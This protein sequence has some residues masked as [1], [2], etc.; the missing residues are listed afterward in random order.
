MNTFLA[1][2]CLVA[3]RVIDTEGGDVVAA[4]EAIA[5]S[6]EEIRFEHSWPHGGSLSDGIAGAAERD[7]R[8]RIAIG[9]GQRLHEL[10]GGTWDLASLLPPAPS[11]RGSPV[12]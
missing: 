7:L 1:G 9:V 11:S 8:N 5:E 3:L 10:V 12:R 2:E 6:S 4:G